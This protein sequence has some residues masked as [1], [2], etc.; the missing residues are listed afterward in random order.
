MM[1][2]KTVR[3]SECPIC[4]YKWLLRVENPKECSQCKRRFGGNLKPKIEIK[5]FKTSEEW[6][7]FKKAVDNWNNE[8]PLVK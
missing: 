4:N 2:M 6:T 5:E 3:V 1:T 7:A 8:H